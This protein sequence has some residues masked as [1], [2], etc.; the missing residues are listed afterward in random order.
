MRKLFTTSLL[1]LAVAALFAAASARAQDVQ[2][3]ITSDDEAFLI[4]TIEKPG[5]EPQ[6]IL[7]KN[8]ACKRLAVIGTEKA[9][10]ALA[11][12]LPYEKLSF[13]ARYA[14]E[15]MPYEACDAALAQAANELTG[16]QLVG[17]VD[18]I[19][20]RG[21]A[22][23]VPQLKE[24]GAKYAD[25]VLVTKAIYAAMG[26]IGS[27]DAAA[28]LADEANKDFSGADFLLKRG[29]GDGIL[30]AA[31]KFVKAG[32]A[33][34]AA[35]LYA[36]LAKPDFPS[37]VQ[38]AG[39]Y[40]W[41][42]TV[43]PEDAA[44]KI[45]AT[46]KTS[47]A[48]KV[49]AAIK[50]IRELNDDSGVAAVN[51]LVA[52]FGD[53]SEATQVRV[54]RAIGDRK[55]DGAR[56]AANALLL[57]IANDGS[58]ALKVAAA[59]A[60]AKNG[61]NQVAA[62]E[63][64][65]GNTAN[66]DDAELSDAIVAMAAEFEADD[67][68]AAWKEI[69]ADDFGATLAK[70][71][72]LALAYMKIAE[73]RRTAEA[74]KTLV[75]VAETKEGALRDGALSALSEIVS[76]DSLDLLVQ[77]LDGETDDAK[78]DWLL[79]AALTRLPREDCAAKVASLFNDADL[80]NKLKILPLLK[81]IGGG[82]A[83]MA[84]ANACGGDTLDKATQILGEWNTP[85]DAEILAEICL[86]IAKQTNDPKY[87]ARGI[88][89]YVRVARQFELPLATKIAMCKTAFETAQ[90]PEDKAL[91]FEVFKRRI[92]AENVAAA[93]EYAQYPEYKEAACE[94][95]VFVA[96]KIR[97]S[98]PDWNWTA[99]TDDQARAA[100]AKIL[101]DGMKKV[102]ETTSDA[103]LKARAQKLL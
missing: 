42:V 44:A 5:D 58:N 45:V 9:I 70:S 6:D 15:S 57:K 1:A 52:A 66:F 17:V 22:E 28:Y 101:V 25:D 99:P 90:R 38:A 87:H 102:V 36:L 92:E 82:T 98:Q 74:G 67:F 51:A 2:A 26:M 14:L 46:L 81:Q 13:S 68:D 86:T 18:T 37:F 89:G 59:Q 8:V 80:E 79:R 94:A 41:I 30:Y 88:R 32:N 83:L 60:L 16:L 84:V 7:V 49:S 72:N 69:C 63:T 100:A 39:L 103:D 35:E 11:A 91:I 33:A 77:A 34:R 93:L 53:F 29:L 61:V 64:L 40:R 73:L 75:T 10:P 50:S 62:F 19:G 56:Q 3:I 20:V 97:D 71:D 47:D 23:S 27:E 4:E 96:E 24:L 85:E 54:A 76:L 65:A 31:D 55:D 48:L 12:M 95:A 21:K 78:V 43:G